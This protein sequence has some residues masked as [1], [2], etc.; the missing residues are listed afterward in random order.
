MKRTLRLLHIEDCD[1]DSELLRVHLT[2]AG[3]DVQIER[4]ETQAA[5][6]KAL[7]RQAWDIIVSDYVM[8]TFSAPA[9]LAIM[10]QRGLD[11]PFIILSGAIGEDTAVAA[12]RAG[13]HDYLMKGKLARLVP[14]IERELQECEYRRERKRTEEALR[15]AEKLASLG[16]LAASIAHEVNNPLEAVTNLLYLMGQ[17]QMD[18][19][20]RDYLSTAEQELDRVSEIVRQA[21]AFS[22]VST[23]KA[24]ASVA[25]MIEEVLR[26]YAPRI[27]AGNV[28]V[29][30]D[31]DADATVPAELRQVF[32]NLIIN[33][34][35]AVPKGGRV[36][37][38]TWRCHDLH[39]GRPGIRLVV[40]D[41]GIGIPPDH[42]PD[43]FKPFFTTKTNKGNGLG[44]W[45]SREIVQKHG[46]SIRV[47]S[48]VRPG[49]SGTVFSVFMPLQSLRVRAAAG[50]G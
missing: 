6:E 29:A 30:K 40:A 39:S 24:T 44:L 12:M 2:R 27:Q 47:R 19:T 21:L 31:V 42:R 46:G 28:Q 41:D 8:P 5:L 23:E 26:L 4:V 34:V 43:I 45:I 22:R 10:K 20:A 17:C 7:D 16:R 14:A 15:S 18:Q 32:S 35:D 48:S 9:A 13:A 1:D 50:T 38:H 33:A 49:R 37:L 36:R 3:Y 11:L 25:Q